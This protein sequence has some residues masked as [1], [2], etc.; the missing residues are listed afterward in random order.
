MISAGD[1]FNCACCCSG[2]VEIPLD[3][4]QDTLDLINETYGEVT[5]P[6]LCSDCAEHI[7]GKESRRR[8]VV[9]TGSVS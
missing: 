4:N 9:W 2:I 8:L 6:L 5:P 7:A 3:A 1:K